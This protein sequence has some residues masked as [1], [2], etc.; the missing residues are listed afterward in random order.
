MSPNS[1]GMFGGTLNLSQPDNGDNKY[2]NRVMHNSSYK[3]I[4]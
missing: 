2:S 3:T 4:N 1:V